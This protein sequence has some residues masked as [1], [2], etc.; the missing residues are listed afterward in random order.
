MDTDERIQ[1]KGTKMQGAAG[2]VVVMAS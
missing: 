2:R 1:Q